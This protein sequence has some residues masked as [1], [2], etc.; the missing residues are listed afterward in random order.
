MDSP[1]AGP[2]SLITGLGDTLS[3]LFEYWFSEGN[4]AD[5]KH[6]VHS[7]FN[8]CWLPVAGCP[9]LSAGFYGFSGSMGGFGVDLCCV[10]VCFVNLGLHFSARSRY[11]ESFGDPKVLRNSSEEIFCR[12][13]GLLSISSSFRHPPGSHFGYI[14][15]TILQFGIRQW[16]VDW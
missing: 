13:G 7:Q 1:K 10:C 6:R 15:N 16:E 12:G 8:G 9:L 2:R 5:L 14:F 11:W 3:M 4:R